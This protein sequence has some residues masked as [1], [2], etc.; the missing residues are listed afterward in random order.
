M[1]TPLRFGFIPGTRGADGDPLDVL[2]LVDAP[3][4]PGRILTIRMLG[5]IE[6]EQV[7]EG[8]S[9]RN[10]RLIGLA[11]GSTERGN[12]R[13]LKDLDGGL[14]VRI[15]ASF[16]DDDRLRGRRF[17]PIARRGPRAARRLIEKA[18]IG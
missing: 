4:Y 3:A 10:D 1:P 13:Q 6:A 16:S 17:E 14:L 12:P 2:V 5:V 15:E 8:E 18:R 7:D 9:V 11:E